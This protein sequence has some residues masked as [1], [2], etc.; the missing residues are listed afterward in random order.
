MKHLILALLLALPAQAETPMTAEEFDTYV[1]GRTLTFGLEGQV[2][3]IE[4]FRPG[5]QTTWA[6][7]T[8]EC[9]K[10]R[11]FPRDEQICFVYEGD[12]PGVEH[13]WIF[14]RGDNGLIAR[15]MG[16]GVGTELYEALNS[17]QPLIC[18]GPE[19]GV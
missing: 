19:V 10:G 6:F 11:W 12:A 1:T 18:R 3:G 4:E 15:F 14:S 16:D 2:Y 17:P 13:C 9:R 8:D 7:M 5:R